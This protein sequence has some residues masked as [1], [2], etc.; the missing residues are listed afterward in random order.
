MECWRGQSE[1]SEVVES[2]VCSKCEWNAEGAKVKWSRILFA[3]NVNGMLEGQSEE[4]V[5]V[6]SFVCSKCER[7]AGGA[8]AK[9]MKWLRVLV[10]AN[11]NGML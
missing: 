2:F 11:V 1:G 7:N 4:D 6:E 10:A 3:V 9:R 8:R 5:V